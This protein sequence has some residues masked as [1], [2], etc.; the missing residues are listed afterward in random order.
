M[1]PSNGS[2][3]VNAWYKMTPTANLGAH[4]GRCTDDQAT[5]MRSRTEMKSEAE[6]EDDRPAQLVHKNVAGFQ[7]AMN[8]RQNGL[9]LA[10]V[11]LEDRSKSALADARDDLK[12]GWQGRDRTGRARAEKAVRKR[13]LA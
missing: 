5:A 9:P 11:C 1:S 6:I 3:P 4:V 2:L 10:V 7:I 8:Q 13:P 12:S